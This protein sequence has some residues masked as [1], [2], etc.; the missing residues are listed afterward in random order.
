MIIWSSSLSRHGGGHFYI[1]S[2]V[3]GWNHEP[4]LGD[5]SQVCKLRVRLHIVVIFH[6]SQ[7]CKMEDVSYSCIHQRVKL[8]V[9]QCPKTHEEEEDMSRVPYASAIGSLMYAMVCTRPDIAHAMGVLSRYMSKL[10]KEH[11]TIVKR[12]FRYLCGTAS[13]GLCYQGRPGLDRVLDIHGFV[14]ANW[15]GDLDHRRSTS[16]YVFNLFGGAI[17]WMRKRQVVV[18]LSTTEVEYMAATHASKEAV[19]LQRL[20]SGIGLVQQA[21]R[22]DCD[23]QSAI[24][25]AKNPTYHSKTKHIDIQY[26]FVRD[27]VEEKKV[28]LMKVDTLKNVADSLTKYVSTEKFSWCRGSMGIVA[29]DC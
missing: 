1:P 14:D 12:V 9:D 7:V 11:W 28:L 15:V 17:S 23:S 25:L 27:M 20:C 10:G 3:P 8:S 5:F 24:F 18:A 29:L 16:G 13:Y 26:H 2:P 4:F 19:W 22:I 6:I 21:V